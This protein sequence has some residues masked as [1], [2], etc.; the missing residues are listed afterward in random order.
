MNSVRFYVH[1]NCL[2][3][4]PDLRFPWEPP[5]SSGYSGLQSHGLGSPAAVGQAGL[6]LPSP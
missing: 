1:R 3:D 4:G 6:A 2:T 5:R